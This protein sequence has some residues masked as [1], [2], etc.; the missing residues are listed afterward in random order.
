MLAPRA[1]RSA[2]ALGEGPGCALRYAPVCARAPDGD[3][4]SFGNA[5]FLRQYEALN[6]IEM[7]DINKGKCPEQEGE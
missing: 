7:I 1:A 4:L 3:R 2:T 6:G 5:C